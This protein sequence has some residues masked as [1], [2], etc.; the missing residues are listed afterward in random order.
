MTGPGS[1]LKLATFPIVLG[2][3]FKKKLLLTVKE[4]N[5]FIAYKIVGLLHETLTWLN[6][7]FL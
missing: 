3:Y 4:N 7:D 2:K 1:Y 5:I 6:K